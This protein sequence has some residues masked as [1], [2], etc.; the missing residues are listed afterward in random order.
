MKHITIITHEQDKFINSHFILSAVTDIW[1]ESGLKVTVIS[2]PEEFVPADLAILHTNLTIV[3]EEYIQL[4]S[5]YPITL[6]QNV[7]DIS[8]RHVSKNI[9]DQNSPY[10]GEVI[11]KTNNNCGGRSEFR[12]QKKGAIIT[13][14]LLSLQNKRHWTKRSKIAP[15]QYRVF[16]SLHDVPEQVWK[17]PYLVVEKFTPEIQ[18]GHY[19]LRTWLFLGDKYSHALSYSKHPIVKSWTVVKRT[20][21]GDPPPQLVRMRKQLGFDY[22]KFDYVMVDNEPILLDANRTPSFGSLDVSKMQKS[23]KVLTE[24]IQVYFENDDTNGKHWS[25]S[26]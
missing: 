10:T 9:L 23:V 14:L 8:K 24:G 19:C 22:G 17:N 11:V 3:P 7:T 6:N 4:A 20:V 1:K 2:K 18:D 13:G 15:E 21:L 26:V 5:R 25:L 16:K 12:L